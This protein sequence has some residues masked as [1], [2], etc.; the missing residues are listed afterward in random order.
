VKICHAVALVVTAL[1]VAGCNHDPQ[2]RYAYNHHYLGNDEIEKY[3]QRKESVTLS[4]GDAKEVNAR[5][6]MIQAWPQ[7]VG[8]RRIAMSGPRAVRAI[9]CYYNP[10][11]QQAQGGGQGQASQNSN[12]F[13]IQV[14]G[15][16]QS[17][18]QQQQR[19]C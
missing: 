8:D 6:H 9:D 19:S 3:Y 12:T 10:R 13:N 2:Y 17:Q 1:A 15:G 14:G 4:A 7:G 16:Q 5:T 11:P 18:G